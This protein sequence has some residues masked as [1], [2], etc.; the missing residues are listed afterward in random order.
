MDKIQ[1]QLAENQ[2]SSLFY[3]H[4]QALKA[5]QDRAE[6]IKVDAKK[7]YNQNNNKNN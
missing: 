2:A 3:Y 1:K 5:K 6:K 4:L 7:R